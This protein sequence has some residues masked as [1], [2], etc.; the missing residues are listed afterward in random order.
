MARNIIKSHILFD[1]HQSMFTPPSCQVAE[2]PMVVTLV[3]HVNFNISIDGA[4]QLIPALVLPL[5]KEMHNEGEEDCHAR[6][7]TA[8]GAS[9]GVKRSMRS[10]LWS[11]AM[12]VGAGGM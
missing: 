1:D 10:Q 8:D 3:R 7:G 9:L 4:V 6:E 5:E 11:H 2:V 12:N